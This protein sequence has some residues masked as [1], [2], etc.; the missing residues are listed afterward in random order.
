MAAVIGS[1]VPYSAKAWRTGGRTEMKKIARSVTAKSAASK[2]K[3]IAWRRTA[4][5]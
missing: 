2:V 5:P 3:R 1:A 4:S